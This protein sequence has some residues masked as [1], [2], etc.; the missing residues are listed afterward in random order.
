MRI[1]GRVCTLGAEEGGDVGVQSEGVPR[2][3]MGN[4]RN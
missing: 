4:V 3:Y 2:T 1:E